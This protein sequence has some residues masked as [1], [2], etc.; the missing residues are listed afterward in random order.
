METV[1]ATLREAFSDQLSGKGLSITAMSIRAVF[2]FLVWLVI[3]RAADRRMLGLYSAFDV[4]LSVMVGAVLGRTING[5]AQLWG[6]L[7]AVAAL[8]VVHWVLAVATHRWR[9]FGRLIK[10]EPRTLVSEGRICRDQMRKSFLTDNDLKEML[11]LRCRLA[12]PSEARLAV[13]ER[14][15][16]ISAIPL[17]KRLRVIDVA[18]E[19]DVQTVRLEFASE[20]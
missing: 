13:L 5:G 9:L 3:V 8:V 11:R 16:Q 15:G 2:V 1:L 14:N 17:A 4:V 7:A 10:G 20:G 12:D 19:S 6:S 18:V